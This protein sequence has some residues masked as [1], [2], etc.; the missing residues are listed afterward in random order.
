MRSPSP[1]PVRPVT[2]EFRFWSPPADPDKPPCPYRTG[3]TVDIKPH[4]P[5]APFGGQAYGSTPR[6]IVSQHDLRTLRQTELLLAN[7][8]L[9]TADSPTSQIHTLSVTVTRE[10]A[11]A[12]DRDAQLVLCNIKPKS[13]VD[14]GLPFQAVAKIYDPL[15]YSFPHKDAPSVPCDVTWSADQDYSREAAAYEHLQTIGQAGSFAPKY[16]GSWTFTLS[17]QMGNAKKKTPPQSRSVRLILIEYIPGKSLRELCT[18]PA[19]TPARML[20]EAYRLEVL[21]RILDGEATLRFK[22]INQRDLAARN[23]ILTLFEDQMEGQ[24]EEPNNMIS[25]RVVLIDY[26]ISVVYTK[27]K[28]KIIPYDGTTLPPNPMWTYWKDNLQ[29]FDGWIP[30]A[31]ETNYRL[32]QEWLKERFGGDN[33]ARYAPV[34]EELEFDEYLAPEQLP[35]PLWGA[36]V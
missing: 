14:D 10:L 2:P 20:S 11:V 12:D 4:I 35:T 15:Y 16:F 5:P 36:S 17:L 30:D 26:N 19:P 27:T 24:P 8:P 6:A 28:R 7:P 22:G 3:F 13:P 1:A 33:L 21:A 34:E 31:W 18:G 9:E 25:P 29:G 23:V 32:R